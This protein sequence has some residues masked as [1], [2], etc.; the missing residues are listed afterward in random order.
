MCVGR[1]HHESSALARQVGGRVHETSMHAGI[2]VGG[3]VCCSVLGLSGTQIFAYLHNEYMMPLTAPLSLHHLKNRSM[4]EKC[5]CCLGEGGCVWGRGGLCRLSKGNPV[6]F[7][8]PSENTAC[9]VT[10][11]HKLEP[12]QPTQT[13]PVVQEES[14][15]SLAVLKA[16]YMWSCGSE[17]RPLALTHRHTVIW[18]NV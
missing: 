8:T 9:T 4:C 11:K 6:P 13:M 16:S 5:S 2:S 12:S 14:L 15:R 7:V 17:G 3:A 10:T 1:C 18:A